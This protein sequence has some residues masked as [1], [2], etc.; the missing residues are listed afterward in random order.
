[1]S[2]PDYEKAYHILLQYWD[3]L[4]DED[5]EELY[6]QLEDCGVPLRGVFY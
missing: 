2:N 4:P 6:K 5:K 1:V 3:S